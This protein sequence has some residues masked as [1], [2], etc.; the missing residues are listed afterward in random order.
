MRKDFFP[1]LLYQYGKTGGSQ[2][3]EIGYRYSLQGKLMILIIILTKKRRINKSHSITLIDTLKWRK[4]RVTRINERNSLQT[5]HIYL[6]K[7][8]LYYIIIIRLAHI[9]HH[10]SISHPVLQ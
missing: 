8:S 4:R 5:V 1:D 7:A 10:N 2:I 9:L 6:F 3:T